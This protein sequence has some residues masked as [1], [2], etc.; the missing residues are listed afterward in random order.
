MKQHEM[1]VPRAVMRMIQRKLAA[2]MGSKREG[3]RNTAEACD[4]GG[5]RC[6][7]ENAAQ[8]AV[9]EL[10]RSGRSRQQR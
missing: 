1:L 10:Q 3:R 7:K 4:A 2:S 8:E 9:N 6:S 5:V